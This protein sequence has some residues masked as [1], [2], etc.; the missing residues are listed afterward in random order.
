MLTQSL[1]ILLV[2]V[3]DVVSYYTMCHRLTTLHVRLSLLDC[4]SLYGC[5][6][7]KMPLFYDL[8]N[9]TNDVVE[10]NKSNPI[11]EISTLRFDQRVHELRT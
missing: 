9:E 7:F 5:Q 2:V 8:V 3:V 10:N 11:E 6:K 1:E 4:A